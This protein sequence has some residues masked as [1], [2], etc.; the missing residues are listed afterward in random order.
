M[1]DLARAY[2]IISNAEQGL[3]DLMQAALTEKRY[4]DL[5]EVAPLADALAEMRRCPSSGHAE[6]MG[7]VSA[8]SEV[9]S[10]AVETKNSDVR[11][12]QQVDVYPRFERDGDK[13]IKIAWSK[14]DRNEY[15]H[16]APREVVFAV[17]D[18]LASKV[19]PGGIFAMDK[20]MPFK[21]PDGNDIP[22]YQAYLA[23]AWF[24][25]LGF[26]ESRGKEGYSIA[27]SSL[28]E[29]AIRDAWNSLKNR[30]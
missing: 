12:K 2:D 6:T 9:E 11:V 27:G 5:G 14:K 15:E 16:R 4:R 30:H 20:F 13:L 19:S 26:V 28:K 1:S 29:A 7:P 10:N 25:V 3:R 23:L 8:R 24:R 21:D 18:V 17:G 22:S